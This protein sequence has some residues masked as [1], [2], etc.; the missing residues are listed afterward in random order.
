MQQNVG[1]IEKIARVVIGLG[2]LSLIFILE[3]NMRWVGL[4]GII[5]IVTA[6]IGWCPISSV[7]GINTCKTK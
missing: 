2:L 4:A 6:A 7:L 5:L 3:G 1:N